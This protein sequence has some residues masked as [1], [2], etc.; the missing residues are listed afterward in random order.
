MAFLDPPYNVKIDSVVGRG[1]RKHREFAM[2]SGEMD[3]DTFRSFLSDGLGAA[4]QFSMDVP[5]ISCA[6]T[7]VMSRTRNSRPLRVRGRC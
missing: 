2:A 6:W 1:A 5:F 4:A 7:G 3:R